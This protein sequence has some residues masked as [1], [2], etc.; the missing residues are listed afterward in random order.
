[1]ANIDK[2]PAPKS[3]NRIKLERELSAINGRLLKAP[4][5]IVF[6]MNIRHIRN[7]RGMNL[8]EVG[9]RIDANETYVGLVERGENNTSIDRLAS[10]AKAFDVPLHDLLNPHMI[11]DSKSETNRPQQSQIRDVPATPAKGRRLKPDK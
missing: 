5:R 11:S 7:S 4:E 10:F 3:K 1:M 2:P 6:G 9:R 8:A